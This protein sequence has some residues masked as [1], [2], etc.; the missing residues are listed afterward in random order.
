MHQP[1]ESDTQGAAAPAG[2]LEPAQRWLEITAPDLF[3]PECTVAVQR[4]DSPAFVPNPAEVAAVSRAVIKRQREFSAGRAAAHTALEKLGVPPSFIGVGPNRNPLWPAGTTGSITH[5]GGLALA[6]VARRDQILA[7]GIDLEL[8][9]AV[10]ADLWPGILTATE[11]VWTRGQPDDLQGNWATLIFCAKECFFK[12]QHPLTSRWVD[13]HDAEV[14]LIPG[15]DV[16]SL[17]C[18]H[19]AVTDRLGQTRF[20]GRFS[21]AHGFTLAVMHLPATR[22]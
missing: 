22:G 18:S 3:P 1:N 5:T 13:F 16:F 21:C 12:L 17:A 15:N 7:L 14:S 4:Y 20:S 8:S 11:I 6:A 10:K 2:D 19:P 9:G